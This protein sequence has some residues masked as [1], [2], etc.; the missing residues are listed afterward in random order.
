MSYTINRQPLG[1][2]TDRVN[3]AQLHGQ[4]E[5]S[6][7]R[8]LL[9]PQASLAPRGHP[10][11]ASGRQGSQLRYRRDNPGN[12]ATGKHERPLMLRDPLLSAVSS[13]SNTNRNSQVSTVSTNASDGRKIKGSIGPW[14]LGTT[15]GR[16]ATARVRKGRH[17]TTGQ[18]VAI[19]IVQKENVR[20]SQAGSLAA[21]DAAELQQYN[22]S[23]PRRMPIGIEREVAIM[24]L[25]QHDHVLKLYDIW[26]NRYEM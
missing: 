11:L 22:G 4:N 13:S 5:H 6:K 12:Q 24:K 16:G 20:M 14:Q 2:A 26:E 10:Q 17:K 15:L 25:I 3:N 18:D 21:L 1:E 7:R 8:T 19:K 9:S 23:E